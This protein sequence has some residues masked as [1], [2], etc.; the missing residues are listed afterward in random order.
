MRVDFDRSLITFRLLNIRLTFRVNNQTTIFSN[1]KTPHSDSF[2]V[3][4]DIQ[5]NIAEQKSTLIEV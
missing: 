4:K 3:M 5:L 2:K 1:L